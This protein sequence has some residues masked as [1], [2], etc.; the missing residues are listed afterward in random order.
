MQSKENIRKPR[1]MRS[2]KTRE[3]ILDGAYQLFCEKGYYATTTNEIA[4]ISDV[5]IGSLYSYFKDKD[6]L[7]L[8]I[9]DRYNQSFMKVHEDLSLEMVNYRQ[10]PKLWFERFIE[11]MI[12]IHRAS[13]ELNR[14]LKILC[15]SHPEV[16]S[17]MERQQEKV[18]QA[19]FSYLVI[20]KDM[21]RVQD[22]E[23]AAIVADNLI[24]SVVDQ[25]VFRENPIGDERIIK[26]GV[27]AVY[28]YLFG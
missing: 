14:E 21:L 12:E 17:V 20:F 22:L 11:G 27:A 4:K 23:A 16:A 10:N 15:H 19:T 24:S 28:R 18:R 8:E 5:S 26:E 2:I 6:T 7:L 13:R 9:L 25:V 1:Q 3:K